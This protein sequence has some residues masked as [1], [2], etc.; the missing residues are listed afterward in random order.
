MIFTCFEPCMANFI[1]PIK[2]NDNL[3]IMNNIYCNIISHEHIKHAFLS[4]SSVGLLELMQSHIGYIDLAFLHCGSSNVSSK[5]LPERLQRRTGCIC[6]AL[7]H[8]VFSN[9][10]LKRMHKRMHNHI[11]YIY[12]VFLHCVFS[13]ASSNCQL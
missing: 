7:L 9:V 2:I 1:V 3:I 13:N 10:S 8:C 12:V 11:G 6:L 5:C 4:V